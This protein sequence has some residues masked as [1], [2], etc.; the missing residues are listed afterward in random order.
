MFAG[1]L[2]A[3]LPIPQAKQVI[4]F[5]TFAFLYC[6]L[7]MALTGTRLGQIGDRPIA[8]PKIYRPGTFSPQPK[9]NL[10]WIIFKSFLGLLPYFF[11]W[12]ATSLVAP[13]FFARYLPHSFSQIN[14][15]SAIVML[16]MTA[17][18]ARGFLY[19]PPIKARPGRTGAPTKLPA[20]AG[21]PPSALSGRP[22]A[23]RPQF[24]NRLTGI[25]LAF[26]AECRKQL[27]TFSAL[28]VALIIVWA[29]VSQVRQVPALPEFLRNADALPFS[30]HRAQVTEFITWT[31]VFFWAGMTDIGRVTTIRPLR[32]LPLSTAKLSALPVG[33]ALVAAAMLWIVLLALHFLVLGTLPVSPRIDLFAAFAGITALSQTLRVIAPGSIPTKGM[34]AFLPIMILMLAGSYALDSWHPDI[35]QPT[36]LGGGLLLLAASFLVMRLSVAGSSRLYRPPAIVMR[37]Q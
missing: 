30:S 15:A 25:H 5:M 36:M 17:V 1:R 33:L 4:L 22:V 16:V 28:I 8:E 27:I 31:F 32:A 6:S 19:N 12:W 18:A 14:A 37:F 35:V 20:S 11:A 26:F 3:E 2:Q 7:A 21:A 13:F 24:A 9:V 10:R 34:I 29:V 23:A